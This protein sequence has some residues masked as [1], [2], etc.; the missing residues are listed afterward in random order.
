MLKSEELKIE[1]NELQQSIQALVDAHQEVPAEMVEEL[2]S[3]KAE[4]EN[5]Q[6]AELTAKNVQNLE[7]NKMEQK[8]NEQFKNYLLG[9][10][11]AFMDTANGNHTAAPTAGG[12]LVPQELLG[13]AELNAD[14]T[15]LR[16]V[17][18]VI[19]AS[20]G[21]GK[22]PAIN[23]GQTC[24]LVA[25]D[26][27]DQM[28]EKAATFV[29]V[30]YTMASKGAII[31]VSRELINDANVDVV[32][33][34]GRLF[35]AVYIADV[36]TSICGVAETAAAVTPA[37]CANVAAA[38]DE[39]K[40]QVIALPG[41]AKTVVIPKSI[42]GAMA[43]EKNGVKGYLLAKDANGATV[44]QIEGAQVMVVDDACMTA[45]TVLVGDFST[46]YHV[47]AP[48]IEVASSEEAGFARNSCLVRCVARY[49]DKAV[50]GAALAKITIA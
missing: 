41:M 36:N 44:K 38:I 16:Q 7:D 35:N 46:V 30:P 22:I 26:E 1:F 42:W 29:S 27:N 6:N 8:F 13:L 18:T 5:L 32:A 14:A 9:D 40:K 47:E 12:A 17:C 20:S 28:T 15:D 25:F 39:I 31:P 37:Q 50:F 49:I 3:L 23:Y 10:K 2:S 48:G 11:D 24:A 33:T 21:S 19:N 34:V 45:K 4:Y 43:I